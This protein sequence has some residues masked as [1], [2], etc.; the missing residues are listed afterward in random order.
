MISFSFIGELVKYKRDFKSQG[1]T[2]T[3]VCLK[4]NLNIYVNESLF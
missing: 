2:S 4:M 3:G 1:K